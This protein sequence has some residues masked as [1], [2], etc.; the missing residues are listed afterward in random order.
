[1][2]LLEHSSAMA[3]AIKGYIVEYSPSLDPAPAPEFSIN[4]QSGSAGSEIILERGSSI[5]LQVDGS[6]SGIVPV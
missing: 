6:G 3:E 5:N 2:A 1:M 4:G